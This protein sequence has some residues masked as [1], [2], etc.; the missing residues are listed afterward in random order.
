MAGKAT[1]QEVTSLTKR[2][3]VSKLEAPELEKEG[4]ENMENKGD[5]S[6]SVLEVTVAKQNKV[7]LT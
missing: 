3:R 7:C 1:E 2:G 5:R 4:S 6:S